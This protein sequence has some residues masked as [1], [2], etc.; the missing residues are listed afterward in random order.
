[1]DFQSFNKKYS[2][3]AIQQYRECRKA[4]SNNVAYQIDFFIEDV[5]EE[6]K[7]EVFDKDYP[8]VIYAPSSFMYVHE[9]DINC[10]HYSHPPYKKE[11]MFRAVEE[12]K[13][14]GWNIKIKKSWNPFMI[15]GSF[16][17]Y[18]KNRT[19]GFRA[20]KLVIYNN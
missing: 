19:L 10:R 7:D 4:A 1:M 8:L 15:V 18:F 17:A 6:C 11:T 9:F 13:K 20:Y 14:N 12:M 16:V 2:K 5:I 3:E